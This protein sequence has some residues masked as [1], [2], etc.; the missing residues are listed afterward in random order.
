MNLEKLEKTVVSEYDII[1]NIKG[2]AIDMIHKA[3]SGHPGIVL[4]AAPILYT[5]FTRHLNISTND[6]KWVNRDRFVM[7][8]GHGSAL[9]YATL[10]MAGYSLSI[11]DLKNFRRAGYR[12]PGHPEYGVTPGVDVSTGPLGQGI[13]TAVGM[14]LGG[15]ILE[16]RYPVQPDHRFDRNTK[17]FDHYVYVLCG[18][19]DLMEGI[20]YEAA[21]FAGT[22]ALDHLIV[23][24]DSNQISLDGE[25]THT[26]TEDV[27]ERFRALGW[28]TDYVK[29][30]E[31]IAEIDKAIREAKK[32]NQPALIEIRTVIGRGSLLEGTNVVHGK[33]LDR[34]DIA[35]LKHSLG[36]SDEPFQY[37]EFLKQEMI[38]RVTDHS[39]KRYDEWA[40]EY[41][42]LRA[43]DRYNIDFLFD[44]YPE[45]DLTKWHYEYPPDYKEELRKI[46]AD[47]MNL[48]PQLLP[49][50]IGG[51][52]DLASSTKTYLK[53]GGDLSKNDY[54]GTNIWYGVREHAMGAIMNGLSL[55]KFKTYGS[56]FLS[57]ADYVKPAMRMSA[58][59]GL[60][61]TY[62]F[63]HD[64]VSIGSDG[65]THQ[66]VEQM[67]MIRAIPNMYLFRPADLNEV[68]GTWNYILK[69]H[70]HPNT[71]VLSK[72]EVPMLP[73]DPQQVLRGGYIVKPEAKQLH[74][75]IIATGTEVHTALQLAKEL[76][77]TEGLDLR[78]ISMPCME[79]FLEQPA[80][81]REQLLPKGVRTF[82]LEAGSSFGWHQ[83]VYHQE[84]LLTIDMFGVSGTKDEAL[85]HVH[86]QY[87][88]LL[89]RIK[90][91]LK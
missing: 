43:I 49:N 87:D 50:F 51:S 18:D 70:D 27:R 77:E 60:D 66:P 39:R 30:G 72:Q 17:V 62:I 69:T 65:P 59:M 2:L 44:H 7:S 83:F 73:V 88:T 12:T 14:A 53:D 61:P 46:N 85:R 8:A 38:K 54:T 82:V 57:F 21:S 13:G 1:S 16:A 20:S 3:G 71:I 64:S 41:Q 86:F 58:L 15:K 89:E 79:L 37:S 78:I 42:E 29:N 35:Q 32:A 11:E 45:V 80:A 6:P 84:Y 90:Q 23:L 40:R 31:S 63:T 47:V 55:M 34:E 36:L 76:K 25:T 22:H 48:I 56:T 67:A 52:A 28:Y 24:Y 68:I 19:G 33:P 74:G 10:F 9:L 26:F 4:G 81:Y 75:I 91:K 5:L